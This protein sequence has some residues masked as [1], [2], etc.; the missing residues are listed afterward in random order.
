MKIC[1]I[2]E[3]FSS[4]NDEQSNAIKNIL[5]ICKLG[6]IEHLVVHKKSKIY[7]NKELL[8][9]AIKKCDI[10]HF[11]GGWTSF[12]I[13]MNSLAHKLHKKII[14][15]PMNFNEPLSLSQKIMK[16]YLIW[17]FY[18]KKILLKADLIHCLSAIEEQNFK[19]INRNFKT[20]ILPLGI[21]QKD[22]VKKINYKNSKKCI[23]FSNSLQ[24]KDLNKLLKAWI[25]IDNPHWYLDVIDLKSQNYFSK[26]YNV[27]KY[28]KIKIIQ[29]IFTQKSKFKSLAKY[30]LLIFSSMGQNFNYEILEALARGLPVLT[31]NSLSWNVIQKKNAGWIINDSIIEFKLILYQIFCSPEKEIKIKRNNTIK[32]AKKFTKEK[33]SKLYFKTYQKILTS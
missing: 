21:N 12:Y 1:F 25:S 20:I 13:K 5:D 4:S 2:S 7:S 32:I 15:H 22:I 14:I 10:L 3:Y 9:K 17:N 31:T 8:E 23:L 29:N 30:D 11:F 16:K 19:K 27:Q 26:I 24:K 18:Q 33:L 28:K 6:K